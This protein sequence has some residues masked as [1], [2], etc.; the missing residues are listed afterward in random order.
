MTEMHEKRSPKVGPKTTNTGVRPQESSH[1][2]TIDEIGRA[3]AQNVEGRGSVD[4][5]EKHV[6]DIEGQDGV[7]DIEA[8]TQTWSKKLMIIRYAADRQFYLSFWV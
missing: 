1:S 3:A 7:R 4:I 2:A 8:I 5:D 6:P